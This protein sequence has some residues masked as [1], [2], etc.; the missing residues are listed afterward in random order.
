MEERMSKEEKAGKSV[1]KG[2]DI[3]RKTL[4]KAKAKG[5][6]EEEPQED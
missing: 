4:D 6:V 2:S 1:D 3:M 5:G